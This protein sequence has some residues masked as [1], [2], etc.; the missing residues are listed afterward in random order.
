MDEGVQAVRTESLC[1]L[2]M[3]TENMILIPDDGSKEGI[4]SA[5]SQSID[6]WC[7]RSVPDLN[8]SAHRDAI[9]QSKSF[10]SVGPSVWICI[11][12]SLNLELLSLS[13]L[14]PQR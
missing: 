8:Y 7:V 12:H 2:D 4:V 13:P 3:I 9:P 5:L 6:S 10:A 1:A 11:P 14:Q